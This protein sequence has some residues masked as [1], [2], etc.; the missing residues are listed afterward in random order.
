MAAE[1]DK[2]LDSFDKA[3][4]RREKN[5]FDKTDVEEIFEAANQFFRDDRS[6]DEKELT[7]IREKFVELAKEKIDRGRA[8]KKLHGTSRAEAIK[9]VL[10]SLL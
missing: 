7:K 1:F 8:T 4:E 6:V 2:L 5:K 3:I 10:N 9:G